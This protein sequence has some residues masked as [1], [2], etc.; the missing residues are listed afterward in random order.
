MTRLLPLLCAPLGDLESNNYDRDR[1]SNDGVDRSRG[2]SPRLS[3][4]QLKAVFGDQDGFEK[5][6]RLLGDETSKRWLENLLAYRILSHLHVRLPTN[7]RQHWSLRAQAKT[8]RRC[9]T[10]VPRFWMFG[11]LERFTIDFEH[12]H[13]T[14]ECSWLNV[15]WTFL[16]RQYYFERDGVRIRPEAGDRIIDAGTGF[17]DTALAFAA[18]V[19]PEGHVYSFDV[20]DSEVVAQNLRLNPEVAPRI[21]FVPRPLGDSA[22]SLP[23]FPDGSTVA[24][25]PG[26]TSIDEFVSREGVDRIDFIKMDV[27]GAELAALRGAESTLRRFRPRLAISAYHQEQDLAALPG[28]IDSLGLGYR[29]FLDHYTT[30]Y[31]ETILYAV[32]D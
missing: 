27:E 4:R 18:S 24:Q 26:T 19:G 32:A 28:W 22:A 31:E 1:W 11:P 20:S 12:Q 15:A 2:V 23:R 9:A 8:M 3:F 29:F 6:W 10:D 17:G 13:L 30:H 16:F 7:T 14:I 25:L 21:T 5:T